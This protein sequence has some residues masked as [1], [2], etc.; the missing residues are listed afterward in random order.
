MVKLSP[1]LVADSLES[2]R[3]D[4]LDGENVEPIFDVPDLAEGLAFRQSIAPDLMSLLQ[5]WSLGFCPLNVIER[6]L[7]SLIDARASNTVQRTSAVMTA[8]DA[9]AMLARATS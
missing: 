2:Y 9:I 6:T 7:S 5:A 8:E 4:R 3:A 1:Y